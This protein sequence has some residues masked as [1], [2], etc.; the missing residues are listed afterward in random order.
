M[1]NNP[2]RGTYLKLEEKDFFVWSIM[3]A[4][5]TVKDLV[6]AYFSEFGSIAFGRVTDLVA[7]LKASGFL[8]DP[9]VD[10]YR[11]A[12]GHYYKRTLTYRGESLIRAF[13]QKEI[14]LT[15]IDHF[16]GLLYRYVF[17]VF[18]TKPAFL[19]Y[20]FIIV[21]GLAL[22]IYNVQQAN[23]SFFH[24]GGKWYWGLLTILVANVVV[25]AIHETSHAMTTKHYGRRVRRGGVML[26]FGS[27]AFFVDTMDI[28]MSPK[29]ARIIVSWA[30]PYSGLVVGSVATLIIAGTGFA[31]TGMNAF[32]F[33]LS[34]MAF[35]M[36][37]L[38]NMNPLL[39]WDAY[40]MLMDWLEIPNLRKR[41]IDFV[42]RNVLNKIISRTSFSREEKIFTVFGTMAVLYTVFALSMVVFF[43]QSRAANALGKL[44]DLGS[45][46]PWLLI[47]VLV[48]VIGVPVGT[49]LGSIVVRVGR[50]LSHLVYTRFLEDRPA[51]QVA[52]LAVIPLAAAI[53]ALFQDGES[54][55]IYAA[56]AG[57]LILAA[58][59]RLSFSLATWYMGSRLQW[60]FLSLPWA[61]AILLVAH[62]M[63][64]LGESIS[65]VADIVAIYGVPIALLAAMAYL[66]PTIISFKRTMLQ[67]AW[68]LMVAG[69][70]LLI[71]AALVQ[72]GGGSE[73]YVH[74]LALLGFGAMAGG[75]ARIH[76]RLRTHRPEAAGGLTGDA[77]SDVER[78]TSATKF[79]AQGILGQ[80]VQVYGHRAARRLEAQF[81]EA[82]GGTAGLGIT[83]RDGQ[84][85]EI[86]DG[87]LL[88]RSQ[89]YAAALTHLF[90]VKSE[91]SGRR[92]VERQLQG[93]YRLMPWE[94]REIGDEHLFTRLDWMSGVQR[95]FSTTQSNHVNLLRYA[96][97]LAG[98]GDEDLKAVSDHLLAES[99]AK[100]KDIIVQGEPGKKFYIIESGTVEVW[101]RAE[102]GTE[103]LAV[104]LG[105]GDYFGERALLNDAPRA[106][107]CRAKT[108]V[109]VL[110]LE[111]ENFDALVARR[112]G[113][114]EEVDEAME[115]ADILASMPLFSD[116][117]PSQ[118]KLVAAKLIPESHPAGAQIIRQGD[119]G[120]KFYVVKSGNAEVRRSAEGSGEETTLGQ[121][122]PGEYFGEIALLMDV[123]RT[124]SVHAASD[125]E[126]LSL[127]NTSFAE[128]VRDHLQTSKGLGQVS[129]RRLTQLRRAE[130]LG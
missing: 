28:W 50:W 17:R 82:A 14:S 78:L 10:L 48:V 68:G 57:G 27:P 84:V 94:Q 6:V 107:T 90:A 31:D 64:V 33:K 116:V 83:I 16:L 110:S 65:D 108:R 25:I 29:R 4:N 2:A 1:L 118:I 88:E 23:Y 71:A 126:L 21:A 15:R 127:D 105:R 45:W 76:H 59:F 8:S 47:G 89:Q 106:A 123:P 36:G 40:F 32:L 41:S 117:S 46:I 62:V 55:D 37:A 112:F 66:F 58:G 93:L 113:L 92:F 125:V 91:F 129:S 95:D 111:K 20:P 74:A 67:G 72:L 103:T 130:S 12:A 101:V 122:G 100:D 96:P 22:F 102:D 124:A 13:L 104:E 5:R 80:F 54:A 44:G 52:A 120:D 75:L 69:E 49:A 42:R 98:L 114:A 85:T 18:F 19:L 11:E 30:G 97:L 38:L 86:G 128:L 109:Q 87:S 121:L 56:V 79:I 51:N 9:P 24:T 43:W 7:Q 61:V 119:I 77:I 115:R 60:F 73:S 39:Q 70:G 63:G 81:N 53:P 34:V 3:D 99:Y 35:V 26:F